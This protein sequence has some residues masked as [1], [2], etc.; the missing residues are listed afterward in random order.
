M[1][2]QTPLPQQQPSQTPRAPWPA[3]AVYFLY[4]ETWVE[5]DAY[6]RTWFS[7][8]QSFASLAFSS[9][10]ADGRARM[11]RPFASSHGGLDALAELG[12]EHTL[13]R[14]EHTETG[15]RED[16]RLHR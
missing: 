11:P 2:E 12:S 8:R 5:W 14:P 3:E 13:A 15:V 1:R 6:G 10:S 16:A 4:R 7:E 9:R